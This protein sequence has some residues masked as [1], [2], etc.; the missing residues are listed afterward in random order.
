MLFIVSLPLKLGPLLSLLKL[1][2]LCEPSCNHPEEVTTYF[3]CGLEADKWVG[4]Q[5][6]K[7]KVTAQGRD[8]GQSDWPEHWVPHEERYNGKAVGAQLARLKSPNAGA[9]STCVTSHLLILGHGL[10]LQESWALASAGVLNRVSQWASED[11]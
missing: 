3:N 5:W 2:I 4:K 9:L 10:F 1:H 8:K 11:L 7:G 6:D